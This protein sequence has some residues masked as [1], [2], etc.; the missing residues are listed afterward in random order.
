MHFF[1]TLHAL[2]PFSFYLLFLGIINLSPKPLMLTGRQDLI[3][4]SLGISGLVIVGPLQI[5]LPQAGIIRFG[6]H[7]WYPLV[8]LYIFGVLWLLILSRPRLVL[9]NVNQDDFANILSHLM[10]REGW[11]NLRNE[12]VVLINNLGIQ[13]EI[14]PVVLMK[15]VT[16]R[17]THNKQSNTGWREFH[18]SLQRELHSHHSL[19]NGF[20]W[21]YLAAGLMVA[22]AGWAFLTPA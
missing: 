15:N 20:G 13:F 2:I 4:L 1:S 8:V 19:R 18:Q 9:Y 12:N 21:I 17:A 6:M 14:L 11:A 16:L 5:L 22:T 7:V 3:A 10:E